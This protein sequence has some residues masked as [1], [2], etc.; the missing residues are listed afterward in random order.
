M[1]LSGSIETF[2]T[3]PYYYR[4]FKPFPAEKMRAYAVSSKVG[5]TK[6]DVPECIEEMSNEN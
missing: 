6:Y 3:R 4:C 5:N 2:K 1:K